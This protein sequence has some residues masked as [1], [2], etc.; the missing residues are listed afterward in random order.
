MT[1]TT[2]RGKTVA[3]RPSVVGRAIDPYAGYE[4]HA[5]L[6]IGAYHGRAATGTPLMGVF[7]VTSQ[8][9]TELIHLSRFSGA[10]PGTP[11][12]VRSHVSGK[13]SF[14]SKPE[15]PGSLITVSLDFEGYDV[16]SAFPLTTFQG[17]KWGQVSVTNLGLVDKM[18]G[19]AGILNSRYSAQENGR[20][21]VAANVKALGVV[22]KLHRTGVLS[23]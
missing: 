2:T 15:S 17:K 8:P 5:L 4:D 12:I 6:K 1:G 21:L 19:C 13:V 11:Y 9:I 16:L 7:N 10:V 3:F 14:P 18:S 20:L 23:Q 22:G